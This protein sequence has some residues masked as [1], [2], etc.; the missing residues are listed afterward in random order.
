MVY[1]GLIFEADLDE[2][3]MFSVRNAKKLSKDVSRL[4]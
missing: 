2:N 4:E 1:L 3:V